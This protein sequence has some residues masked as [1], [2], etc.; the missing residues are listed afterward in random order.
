MCENRKLIIEK[1]Y[2]TNIILK[3]SLMQ[4]VMK[5]VVNYY[6]EQVQNNNNA[7]H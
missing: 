3:Q 6:T 7:H 2:S 5:V 4:N 1:W